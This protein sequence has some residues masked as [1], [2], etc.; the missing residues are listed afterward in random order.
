[1]SVAEQSLSAAPRETSSFAMIRTLGGVAIISALLI[2]LVYQATLPRINENRRRMT[3]RA[4]FTVIPGA[5]SKVN[6][7]M[8][9]DGLKPLTEGVVPTNPILYAGYNAAGELQG[10]AAEASAQGYQDVI[11]ILYG[12]DPARQVV[13]GI[14]VLESKE[15]PGLGDKIGKEP[16]FLANFEALDVGLNG[17]GTG[18]ENAVVTVKHGK[19]SEPWQIDAISGATISSNAVGRMINESAQKLVPYLARHGDV[20]KERP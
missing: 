4:V 11:R 13:T 9:P 8:T 3:E 12:Y 17:A 1:M 7:E 16:A 14:T 20:L 15:T 6:L 19:K 10:V 5:E 2:V 18:L